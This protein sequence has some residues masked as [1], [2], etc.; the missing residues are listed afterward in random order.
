MS[1]SLTLTLSLTLFF[2]ALHPAFSESVC[3]DKV[4]N[5]HARHRH[6][7]IVGIL[8]SL[9]VVALLSS[10]RPGNERL[11]RE[12]RKAMYTV[13]TITVSAATDET[14]RRAIDAAFLAL[15]R[16]EKLMNYYSKD[17]EVSEI[18]RN[19]GVRPVRV[20]PETFEVVGKSVFVA[21][22]TEGAFDITL[23]PVIEAWDFEKKTVPGKG[24]INER[25][26]RVGYRNIVLDSRQRTVFLKKG[27]MQINLGGIL[28][29]FAADRAVDVLRKNG[30][31][32]GIVAIG[33]DI[34]AFGNRPGGEPWKVGV[35]NPRQTG[36]DDEILATVDLTDK[37][38]S[39]AGDYERYYILDG[40][41]Y[42]HILDPKTGYPAKGCRSVTVVAADGIAADGFDTG[43]FVL[44]PAKALSIL[45][46]L[47]LD[48]IVV[49]EDGKVFVTD[50]IKGS[51]SLRHVKAQGS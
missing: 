42:H 16:I 39:T 33:G 45:G 28:K 3:N 35:Q 50:G 7:P 22:N 11:F 6:R 48:G 44:G 38:I 43:L 20:S 23:G 26:K 30:I 37:A 17:S 49:D 27:G 12:T 4:N 25:M 10:C 21:E 51:V 19:A 15:D 47:G 2:R 29:G 31:R 14:A 1:F 32:S 24:E 13:T 41:R 8:L 40:V 46:K 18:N 5:R 34:R 36:K 9:L